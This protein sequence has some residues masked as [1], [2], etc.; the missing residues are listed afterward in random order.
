[1]K[2]DSDIDHCPRIRM[3]WKDV[4]LAGEPYY[5]PNFALA[6]SFVENH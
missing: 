2:S 6:V 5:N 1:M 4:F 3:R